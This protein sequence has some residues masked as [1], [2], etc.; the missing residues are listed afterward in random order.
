VVGSVG[1]TSKSRLAMKHQRQY[2]LRRAC[3][4]NE[5][6]QRAHRSVARGREAR[7]GEPARLLERNAERVQMRRRAPRC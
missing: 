5:N 2:F 4:G 7:V 6:A 1:G 3:A